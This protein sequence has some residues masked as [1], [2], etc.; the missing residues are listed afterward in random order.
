MVWYGMAWHGM[1]CY[2][3]G[4]KQ[5]FLRKRIITDCHCQPSRNDSAR[6]ICCLTALLGWLLSRAL[7]H[8]GSLQA[9][10]IRRNQSS[11]WQYSPTQ[12]FNQAHAQLSVKHTPNESVSH[13]NQQIGQAYDQRFRQAHIQRFRSSTPAKRS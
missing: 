4:K 11:T 6:P 10:A 8:R 5:R 2:A 3:T 13:T 12:R 7:F 9:W 1:V